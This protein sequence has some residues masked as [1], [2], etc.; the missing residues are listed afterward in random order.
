[1]RSFLLVS[2]L[3]S[4]AAILRCNLLQSMAKV[5]EGIY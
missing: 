3:M 4:F 2:V 5:E 1:M